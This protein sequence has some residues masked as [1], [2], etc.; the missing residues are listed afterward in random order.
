MSN[1][2]NAHEALTLFE[3]EEDMKSGIELDGHSFSTDELKAMGGEE[4][5]KVL[6]RFFQQSNDAVR[7][8]SEE[9]LRE[10]AYIRGSVDTIR[11]LIR[12]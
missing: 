12:S 7:E 5:Q 3:K 4:R 8:R 1:L 9:V 2:Q 10:C 6:S 11:A